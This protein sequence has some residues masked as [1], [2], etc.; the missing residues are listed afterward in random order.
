MN[1]GA[2]RRA[3]DVITR[4]AVAATVALLRR[5]AR[6]RLSARQYDAL[7]D[8]LLPAVV[9]ARQQAA[10]LARQMYGRER[11][12]H[13]V[14]GSAPNVAPPHYERAA[15]DDALRRTV[16]PALVSAEPV[17]EEQLRAAGSAVAR[18][19]EMASRQQ[20]VSLVRAD[21][22]AL[23][24]VRLLTGR[25]DCAFCVLLASRK[26]LYGSAASAQFDADGEKYHDGCDCIVFPVFS[27]ESRP[28]KT[29]QKYLYNVY[30]KAAEAH[31]DTH[32]L[33][34]LRRVLNSDNPPDLRPGTVAA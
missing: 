10:Q 28:G 15:L 5:V 12:R 11:R 29:Q 27:E 2:L 3:L 6:R 13:G 30:R 34:A 20:T 14:A 33:N 19:V 7:V 32:P 22:L 25:E 31:P 4:S 9:R 23:G 26:D 24:W 17:L 1:P 21:K 8:S 18:H 16:R